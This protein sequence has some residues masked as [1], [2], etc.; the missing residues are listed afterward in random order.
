M[1]GPYAIAAS[2]IAG[3]APANTSKT[4]ET[5]KIG[6]FRAHSTPHHTRNP[7]LPQLRNSPL[8]GEGGMREHA[9]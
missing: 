2:K 3:T 1:G 7:T 5:A 4:Q 9:G 8:V 6:V